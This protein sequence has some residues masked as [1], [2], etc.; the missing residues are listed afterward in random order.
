MLPFHSIELSEK[1]L[2]A[3]GLFFLD[4]LPVRCGHNNTGFWTTECE[5]KWCAAPPRPGP[6]R[7]SM[8]LRLP[9]LFSPP[10]PGMET[11]QRATWEV[12][13][14]SG[15]DYVEGY[16]ANF[17]HIQYAMRAR[18]KSVMRELRI[19]LGLCEIVVNVSEFVT[20]VTAYSKTGLKMHFQRR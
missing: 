1:W 20:Y 3:K 12:T 16:C 4:P 17:L 14:A 11:V 19:F 2:P 8:C 9:C 5:R 10:P 13:W 7:P 6:Q 18:R 15:N